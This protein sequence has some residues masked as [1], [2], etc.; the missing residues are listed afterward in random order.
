MNDAQ[1]KE[2]VTIAAGY[3]ERFAELYR[4]FNY[5][6]PTCSFVPYTDGK[7]L[8]L[9]LPEI[10]KEKLSQD[11]IKALQEERLAFENYMTAYRTV[12]VR[13]SMKKSRKT[14]RPELRISL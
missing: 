13:L 1:I 2:V 8:S 14:I 5:H 4:E 10:E 7:R 12:S 11:F 9:R 6:S 3:Q